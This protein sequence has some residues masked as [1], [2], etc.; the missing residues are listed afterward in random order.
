MKFILLNEDGK[1]AVMPKYAHG[2]DEDAGMD[3]CS[4]VDDVINPGEYKIIR[5]GVFIDI[6]SGFEVQVRSRSGLA[7]KHG[8]AVLNSPGT[9][10]PGYK[11]EVK[12]ILINHG[13]KPFE[14]KIGDRIAQLVFNFYFGVK[15]ATVSVANS[16]E[17]V[18]KIISE[19]K[20]GANGVGSTGV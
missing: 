14:I 17:D 10:D 5:T 7:A 12:V 8:V 1:M 4:F 11:G 20:R 13:T 16:E 2:P 3:I 15:D 19:S 6:P 9:I 18:K